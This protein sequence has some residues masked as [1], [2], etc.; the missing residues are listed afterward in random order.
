[1]G[2][3]NLDK[4]GV[5]KKGK[6]RRKVRSTRETTLWLWPSS[7]IQKRKKESEEFLSYAQTDRSTDRST[8][9]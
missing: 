2:R 5:G 7:K 6:E 1:M 4:E 9:T 8:K 3:R